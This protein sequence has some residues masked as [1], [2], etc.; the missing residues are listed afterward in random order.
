MGHLV[1]KSPLYHDGAGVPVHDRTRTRLVQASQRLVRLFTK[2]LG[3]AVSEG[4]EQAI[5][6]WAKA[7][8]RN[9]VPLQNLLDISQVQARTLAKRGRGA[10]FLIDLISAFSRM[11]RQGHWALLKGAGTNPGYVRIRQALYKDDQCPRGPTVDLVGGGRAIDGPDM[12]NGGVQGCRMSC[13]DL[14][15]ELQFLWLLWQRNLV[16]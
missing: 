13:F 11:N 15:F 6:P 16:N 14:V 4:Y 1:P 8:L 2:A 9:R 7:W 10:T 3:F 5:G 12:I